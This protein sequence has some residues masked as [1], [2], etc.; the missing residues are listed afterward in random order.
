MYNSVLSQER[1]ED[2]L[3]RT[4]VRSTANIYH[5]LSTLAVDPDTERYLAAS[6]AQGG[7]LHMLLPPL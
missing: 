1:L 7:N 6:E 4:A 2:K 3:P 5:E